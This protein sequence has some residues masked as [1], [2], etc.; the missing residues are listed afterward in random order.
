MVSFDQGV[1][2]PLKTALQ[3]IIIVVGLVT[4]LTKVQLEKVHQAP[5]QKMQVLGL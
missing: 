2:V 1:V 3:I 5:A 4:V